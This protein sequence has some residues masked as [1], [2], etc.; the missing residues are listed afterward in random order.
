MDL[1]QALEHYDDI[2]DIKRVVVNTTL[3]TPDVRIQSFRRDF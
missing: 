2:A 3:L 1:I